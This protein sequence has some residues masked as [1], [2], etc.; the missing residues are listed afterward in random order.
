MKRTKLA[1]LEIETVGEG[2]YRRLDSREVAKLVRAVDY[3]L[4]NKHPSP[5]KSEE[6]RAR[7]GRPK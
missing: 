3:A 1:S 5:Q 6:H 2:P 4:E 7:R